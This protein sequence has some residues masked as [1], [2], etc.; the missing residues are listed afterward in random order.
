MKTYKNITEIDIRMKSISA[1][2]SEKPE[3]LSVDGISFSVPEH[4]DDILYLD[5]ENYSIDASIVHNRLVLDVNKEGI[6]EDHFLDNRGHADIE[7][8]TIDFSNLNSFVF[9]DLYVVGDYNK[10]DEGI[11]SSD[12][13]VINMTFRFDDDSSISLSREQLLN[14]YASTQA[15]FASSQIH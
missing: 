4:P 14:L 1:S 12:F 8:N 15:D 9:H 10:V 5:T 2:F 11:R 6:D 3:W 7:V 13:I